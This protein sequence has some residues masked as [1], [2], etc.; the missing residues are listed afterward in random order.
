V[1]SRKVLDLRS[2]GAQ[3]LQDTWGHT[4]QSNSLTLDGY[5]A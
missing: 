4:N 3:P 2:A 1:K 5:R